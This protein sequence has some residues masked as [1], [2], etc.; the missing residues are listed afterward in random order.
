MP[1]ARLGDGVISR[2]HVPLMRLGLCL[3]CEDCFE[4]GLD[5]CPACGGETWIPVARFLE[6]GAGRPT[7]L[8]DS[9]DPSDG[10]VRRLAGDVGHFI[11][12]ARDREALYQHLSEG[13]AGNPAVRVV[14]DRRRTARP[15]AAGV[16]QPKQGTA[17][18][19]WRDVDEHLRVL[20][21][22]V[23]RVDRPS[24]AE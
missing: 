14:R 18:R 20:G 1:S 16:D 9:F 6:T 5:A 17:E 4:I 19:R 23:V 13:L 21:W 11:I 7:G 24:R 3:D 2:I 12:V 10:R 15:S 8:V 22:A